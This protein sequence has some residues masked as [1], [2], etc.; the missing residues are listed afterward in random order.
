MSKLIK[1]FF[2]KF[3]T[4][5]IGL[6]IFLL[7]YVFSSTRLISKWTLLLL[8]FGAVYIVLLV[9][10]CK[11]KYRKTLFYIYPFL[12]VNITASIVFKNIIMPANEYIF[13]YV[14]SFAWLLTAVLLVIQT[15]RDKKIN[16]FNALYIL[17]TTIG[18]IVYILSSSRFGINPLL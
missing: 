11:V 14:G 18:F 13:T 12:A 17:L 7:P 5:L 15:V 1:T 8:I 16:W 9:L 10:T 6:V 3:K 2:T 4:E